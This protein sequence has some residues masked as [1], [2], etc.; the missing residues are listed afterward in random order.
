M[1]AVPQSQLKRT[2]ISDGQNIAD[3]CNDVHVLP[4][5][6]KISWKCFF[7]TWYQVAGVPHTSTQNKQAKPGSALPK[8][9]CSLS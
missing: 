7:F 1:M 6:A 8:I 3:M 2:L 9:N 5:H 4:T